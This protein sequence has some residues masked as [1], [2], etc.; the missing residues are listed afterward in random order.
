MLGLKLNH[1]SKNG[2]RSENPKTSMYKTCSPP[3][4][5]NKYFWN[6]ISENY[7]VWRYLSWTIN[8]LTSRCGGHAESTT[9]VHHY[10]LFVL[11]LY[12]LNGKM[13]YRK[14]SWSLEAARLGLRFFNSLWNLTGTRAAELPRCLLNFR[15]IR[16]LYH[17][18]SRLRNFWRSWGKTS[19]RLVNRDPG[20]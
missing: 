11:G 4:H 8:S 5:N 7:K 9:L 19:Y 12:S 17:L 20:I 16:P 2:P 10:L 13:S 18:I 6:E 14:I 3:W 1:V 15:A